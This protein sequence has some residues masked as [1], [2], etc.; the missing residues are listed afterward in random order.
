MPYKQFEDLKVWQKSAQL[1][2]NVYQFFNSKQLF[3]FND[4]ITG[5]VLSISSNIAE[6]FERG[7]NN[8]FI[9]FLIYAKGSC[10]E[11]RSQTQI[12][13]RINYI[14]ED[15]GLKWIDESIVISR[16]LTGLIKTRRIF[17]QR[18]STKVKIH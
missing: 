7:S 12:G 4:Q 14:D 5:A 1:C 3:H 17:I 9:R 11:F 6:G 10:G 15:I 2:V 18:D 8:E 16:M 13:I